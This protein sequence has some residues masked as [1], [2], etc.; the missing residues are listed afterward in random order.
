MTYLKELFLK[1]RVKFSISTRNMNELSG[2]NNIIDKELEI[3][4]DQNKIEFLK[5][6]ISN[7]KLIIKI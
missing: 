4:N 6:I 7:M 3:K 2:N 5:K 1:I